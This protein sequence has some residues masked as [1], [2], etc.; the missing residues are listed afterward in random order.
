[1]HKIIRV[2]IRYYSLYSS[3]F[4]KY[5][6]VSY[7]FIYYFKK[8]NLLESNSNKLDFLTLVQM[9]FF[10][11]PSSPLIPSIIK[12]LISVPTLSGTYFLSNYLLLFYS[13]I[14]LFSSNFSYFLFI[15][16]IYSVYLSI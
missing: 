3:Y 1:M 2:N 13:V 7:K 11:L 4:L 10:I 12:F 9:A 14:S 8:S 6:R 5:L 16:S 15:L